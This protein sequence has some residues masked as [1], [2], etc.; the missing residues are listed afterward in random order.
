MIT[1]QALFE[2]VMSVSS[3]IQNFIKIFLIFFTNL[4]NFLKTTLFASTLNTGKIL[5]RDK[6]GFCWV[7][8]NIPTTTYFKQ[9]LRR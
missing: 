2:H 4:R 8:N 6:K 9:D 1:V 5:N 3:I 7:R